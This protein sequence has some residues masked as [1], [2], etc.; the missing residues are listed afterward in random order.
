MPPRSVHL[1]H[2]E[3]RRLPEDFQG[4]GEESI[5]LVCRPVAEVGLL[6]SP[7]EVCA[8]GHHRFQLHGQGPG[9]GCVGGEALH[10][11]GEGGCWLRSRWERA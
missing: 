1:Q 4:L 8:A 7:A 10:Q 3:V 2:S 5:L 6:R 11:E 9:Q